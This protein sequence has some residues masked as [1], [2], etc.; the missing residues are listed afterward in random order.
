MLCRLCNTE[1][2]ERFEALILGTYATSYFACPR[3]GFVQTGDPVWLE[4]AYREPI[5]ACDTGI[6]KRNEDMRQLVSVLLYHFFDPR[7]QYLDYAGGYGL[8]TRLMRDVGFDFYWSDKY[9]DNIFAKGFEHRPGP[10]EAVTAF[11]VF[12]HL[13][14]PVADIEKML[15]ISRN[16]I[17]TTELVPDPVP[18]PDQWWYYGIEHG[19]HI[20]FYTRRSLEQLA[21]RFGL[22]YYSF[23][24]LHVM[25]D[26]KLPPLKLKL[27]SKYL[28]KLHLFERVRKMM[29][30]KTEEDMHFVLS[31]RAK[32]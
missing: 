2:E 24:Q 30:T 3:C 18:A 1:S 28:R 27:V 31:L 8:F 16:L 10:I 32:S 25:T 20:S 7:R 14:D 13:V 17:F 29:A 9:A 21:A 5:N 19:Q 26:R 12:E 15:A 6:L 23:R 22:N 4:E 11:E